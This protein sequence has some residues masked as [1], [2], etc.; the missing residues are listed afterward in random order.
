M[1]TKNIVELLLLANKD[2]FFTVE[3]IK[4]DGSVRKLNGRFGVKKASPYNS[5]G[6]MIVYDV[7]AR[8]YRT[9][10]LNNVKEVR[11]KHGSIKLA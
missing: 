7:Q 4:K 3:F 6:D 11:M 10:T 5:V 2:K 9:V 8:G 1:V